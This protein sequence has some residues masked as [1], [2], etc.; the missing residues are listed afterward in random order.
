[1]SAREVLDSWKQISAYLG[2]DVRTCRRWEEHLGLP[3]HRLNGSPKARVRAYKDEVDR[4]L[5]KKLHEREVPAAS[6]FLSFL[7]RWPV[8]VGL[9][10]VLA[11]AVLG[12]IAR[13]KPP[14]FVPGSSLPRLVVLP[15]VNLTGDDGLNYLRESFPGH[16]IRDLQTSSDRMMVY[17]LDVVVDAVRRLGLEPGQPLTPEDLADVASRTEADWFLSSR[18][19][20]SGSKLRIDYELRDLASLS[21]ASGAPSSAPIKTDSVKGTEADVLDIADRVA[22][23]V[24]RAYGV[25][26][27]VGPEAME[28]CDHQAIRFYEMA[29]SVERKYSLSIDPADLRKMIEY[30][31]RAREADPGC[32]LVYLGLG[33]AY[34]HKFAYEN[35]DQEALR[36]MKEN[37][38]RG[39][40]MAPERAETNCGAGWVHFIEGDNDQAY[41]YFRQALK[42]DPA[43]IHVLLEIGSFLRSIGLLEKAQEYYT[44]AIKAGGATADMYFLRGWTYE[45]MGLYESALEDFDRMVKLEPLD[46][47][48]RFL[49]ARVLI[50]MKHYEAAAA[51]LAT[52][53]SMEPGE[54]AIALTRALT[55]AAMGR[56]DEALAAIAPERLGTGPGRGAVF[57]SR[58]YAAL[59]M[60]DEALAAIKQGIAHGF[61]EVYEYLFFFPFLNNTR[62]HFYDNLRG[63]PRFAEIL[64]RMERTYVDYLNKYS[65][66]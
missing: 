22:S 18:L 12:W 38:K 32:A 46:W 3:V 10:A 41:D 13:P 54:L 45:H 47:R 20:K 60:S 42:L 17:S 19:S 31:E 64:G 5:E 56:K 6:P 61:E 2:R 24:R 14:I 55:A 35:H 26:T 29:R 23:G 8:I 15:C 43:S 51:E 37:Y 65:D 58:I 34:Q 25:P 7:R 48:S 44:K 36:L 16:V 9:V 33:D 1:M 62:D 27:Q 53:E 30:L 63:D 21:G 49:R 40:E 11:V 59:G 39:Y 66:L 50:L 28:T 4:W 57:K 52:A